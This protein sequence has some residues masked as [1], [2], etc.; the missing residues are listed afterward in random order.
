MLVVTRKFVLSRCEMG[1]R[2]ALLYH[3]LFRETFELD[4]SG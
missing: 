1:Q 3:A 4:L 2:T